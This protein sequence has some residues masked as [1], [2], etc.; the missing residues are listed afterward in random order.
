M[1]YTALTPYYNGA[2]TD[3][4]TIKDISN[5]DTDVLQPCESPYACGNY[6]YH[7]KYKEC[8]RCRNKEMC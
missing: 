3:W 4:T 1:K 6:F 5:K 8:E 7:S 2:P